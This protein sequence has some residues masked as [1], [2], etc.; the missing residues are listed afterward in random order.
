[1]K[2]FR[3]KSFTLKILLPV[4]LLTLAGYAALTVSEYFKSRDVIIQ[5][6]E[7]SSTD[8][9][10]KIVTRLDGML[11]LW[12]SEVEVLSTTNEVRS[13]DFERFRKYVEDRKDVFNGYEMFLIADKNGDFKA[14]AGSDGNISERDYFLKAMKGQVAVSEPVQ[15][16]ATGKPIIAIAAPI[17]DDAGEIAGVVAGT[18][19]LKYLTDI[20][21]SEKFGESG[22]AYMLNKEGL[23]MA[24]PEQDKILKENLLES[25]SASLVEITK[26]M[27]NGETGAGYY[28]YEGSKK[29]VSFSPLEETGW[30]I[31]VT[32]SYS[33]VSSS[34]DE[35]RNVALA[36]SSAIAVVI[37]LV[38]VIIIRRAVKPIRKIAELTGLVAEGDLSV[39]VDFRSNDEIGLLASGFN[40][41]IAKVKALIAEVNEMSTVVAASSAEMN[42]SAANITKS[43]EQV[44][45]AV[46]ELAQGASEQA[47]S[48]DKGSKEIGE[49]ISGLE[50]ITEEMSL[51][52]ELAQNA[53]AKVGIGRESV[54]LQ[55]IKANES[56]LAAADVKEA[57]GALSLKSQEIG[58]ILEV[59]RNIAEQTNLLALNAAI[60]AARAGE[61]GKGFAVVADEIRKLAEQSAVSVKQI[62]GI[63]KEVQTGIN[64]TVKE[65]D[66]VQIAVKEQETALVRTTEA[67]GEIFE[68]VKYLTEKSKEA[69][70]AADDIRSRAGVTGELIV[71]IA[72]IAQQTA[73]GAEEV[74]ASTEE[75]TSIT[76]Q[77]EL[78]ADNIFKLAGSLQ[79]SLQK[80]KL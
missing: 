76:H 75:Q 36:V 46:S 32:I 48:T 64:A 4:M 52:Q 57:V 40:N 54:E 28:T 33:E 69:A 67:F 11:G 23:V 37:M 49:I 19:E 10:N 35:L 71:D 56:K 51:S 12:K 25:S 41:M 30:P 14:T 15:S 58:Q 53:G 47:A 31:G 70:E 13:M 80:F 60:E 74:S 18:V 22:Y 27:V 2:I 3:I 42:E 63:I 62:S 50:K 44:A 1:M 5:D 16:K 43:T 68:S 78:V 29:I 26:R 24:H 17:K 72:S 7:N 6:I 39:R 59:I 34:L 65:M 77:F 66:G 79:Q 61:H 9:A 20:I 45:L 55:Q 8:K 73:A 38:V 21:G